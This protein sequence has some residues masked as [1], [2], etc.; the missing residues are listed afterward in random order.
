MDDFAEPA[1]AGATD[2]DKARRV[3]PMRDGET[4]W[5]EHW[6]W[7]RRNGN[8]PEDMSPEQY[9]RLVAEW[10]EYVELPRTWG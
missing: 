8:R 7:L 6:D 3:A 9:A 1:P 4:G 2:E 10:Q 5:A